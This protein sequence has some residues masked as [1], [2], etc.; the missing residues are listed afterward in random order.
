MGVSA[1]GFDALKTV[2]SQLPNNFVIPIMI[3]QHRDKR[4][5]DFIC[6]YFDDF[7]SSKVKEGEDKE[8]VKQGCIYI[9]PPNYHMMVEM[10]RTLSLSIDLPVNFSRPSVDVLFETAAEVYKEKLVGVIMT[11]ANNDGSMGFKKIKQSGGLLVVQ[12]PKTATTPQM[13]LAAIAAAKVDHI[14]TLQG[15]GRLLAGL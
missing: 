9:A 12:D 11:G 5:D 8:P 3:V 15:I 4:D 7:C 1:G 2:L 10:D 14:L 6:R 13:P